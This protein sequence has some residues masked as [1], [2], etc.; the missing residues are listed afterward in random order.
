MQ[1]YEITFWIFEAYFVGAG[2]YIRIA[3][4]GGAVVWSCFQDVVFVFEKCL[5]DGVVAQVNDKVST[6]DEQ[7]KTK[8]H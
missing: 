2:G 8:L 6:Q 5:H 7:L 4:V 3:S 1:W